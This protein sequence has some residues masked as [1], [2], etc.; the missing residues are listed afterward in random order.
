MPRNVKTLLIQLT[1]FLVT[2]FSCTYFSAQFLGLPA[3]TFEG[4]ML[5]G[6]KFSIP[7]LLILTVHEFGH[8]IAARLY[9][10]KVT[11]PYFIPFIGLIGTMGAFIR[12]KSMPRSRKQFFDIGVS[13]PLAGFVVAFAL[14][15]YGFVTLPPLDYLYN[16]HPDYEQYG[17]NYPEHAFEGL[18]NDSTMVLA[19]GDNLLFKIMEKVLVEDKSRIPHSYEMSHYPLLMAGFIALFFTGLNLL[20]IG[21][22]DGGHVL[23]GLIGRKKHKVV[24]DVF[25]VLL[26]ITGGVGLFNAPL[27]FTDDFIPIASFDNMLIFTPIYL[28][29]LYMGFFAKMS[30]SNV[31]NLLISVVVFVCQFALVELFP[32]FQGFMGYLIFALIIGRFLGTG[33]PAAVVDAPLSKGRIVLGWF[34]LVV[35]F[36]SFSFQPFYMVQ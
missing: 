12:I 2:C 27:P 16:I 34:A 14:L 35:F 21:Q 19:V 7:F 24:S 13:G 6:L 26:V 32:N 33:H 5:N 31:T 28:L 1:L 36:L 9:K 3:K 18:P 4:F 23:Y 15:V 25:Y 10:I 8:Y 20:P 29:I 11:L 30:R 22:L 17:V